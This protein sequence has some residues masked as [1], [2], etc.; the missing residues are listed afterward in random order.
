MIKCMCKLLKPGPFPS[1]SSLD[2]KIRLAIERGEERRCEKYKK[3]RR[4]RGEREITGE[5]KRRRKKEEKNS[6]AERR[7][8][9]RGAL[10]KMCREMGAKKV[11]R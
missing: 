3:I 5:G 9:E 10:R 1:S 6:H 11:Q 7:E 4:E 2:L 8:R